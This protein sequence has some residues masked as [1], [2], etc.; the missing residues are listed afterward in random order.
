MTPSFRTIL[1]PVLAF[2]VISTCVIGAKPAFAANLTLDNVTIAT[3]SVNGAVDTMN[4]GTTCLTISTPVSA[5]CPS[6]YVAI[7]NNNKQLLATALQARATD[8][9]LWFYYDDSAG[10]FHCPGKVFTPCSVISIELK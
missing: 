5:S 6:G 4:P 3:V 1:K 10:P 8:S 9:K 7:Q 2:A